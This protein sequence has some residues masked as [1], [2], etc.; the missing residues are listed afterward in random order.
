MEASCRTSL[1]GVRSISLRC[2]FFFGLLWLLNGRL[3]GT[4]IRIERS[5]PGTEHLHVHH[6]KTVTLQD[7][8][9]V[10]D[11]KDGGAD[12]AGVRREKINPSFTAKAKKTK[13]RENAPSARVTTATTRQHPPNSYERERE[14]NIARNKAAMDKIRTEWEAAY[15]TATAKPRPKPRARVPSGQTDQSSR[16]RYVPVCMLRLPYVTPV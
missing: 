15:G 16:A 6:V 13:W 10:I 12:N 1:W 5:L 7:S 4:N 14:A 8:G 9:S 2:V 3:V 11:D